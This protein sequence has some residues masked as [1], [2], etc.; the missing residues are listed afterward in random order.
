MRSHLKDCPVQRNFTTN[1]KWYQGPIF[2][3]SPWDFR[4]WKRSFKFLPIKHNRNGFRF[5]PISHKLITINLYLK[6][7][8]VL[9]S[10]KIFHSN[11]DVTIREGC[12]IIYIQVRSAL[13]K[14]WQLSYE[15]NGVHRFCFNNTSLQ[16]YSFLNKN[17]KWTKLNVLSKEPVQ[18]F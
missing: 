4:V 13:S 1:K 9:L 14:Q 16:T 8:F 6:R 2:T 5:F 15:E 7:R 11:R 17:I 10:L 3:W 12:K 18:P